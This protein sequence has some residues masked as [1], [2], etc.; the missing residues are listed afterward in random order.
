VVAG[1]G[2]ASVAEITDL[3]QNV[4]AALAD[5]AQLG[6]LLPNGLPGSSDPA[7]PGSTASLTQL[8]GDMAQPTP[9][10]TVYSTYLFSL[11]V[12]PSGH[13]YGGAV[14]ASVVEAAAQAHQ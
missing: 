4:A 14:P 7:A 5:P 9:E 12:T 13:V 3:P 11:L 8:L 6:S 2:W 10:G 1:Q